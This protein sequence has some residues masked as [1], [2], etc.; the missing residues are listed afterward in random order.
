MS[1]TPPFY[2]IH[3]NYIPAKWIKDLNVETK[4]VNFLQ[5]NIG[6]YLLSKK[7]ANIYST[8]NT[9][10]IDKFHQNLKFC[11]SKGKPLFRIKHS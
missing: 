2:T 7:I 10:H 8:E 3:E 11:A 5:E 1:F 6:N 4:N 9:N